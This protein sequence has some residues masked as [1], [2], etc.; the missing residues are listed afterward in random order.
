[1]VNATN[2]MLVLQYEPMSSVICP[3]FNGL[4]GLSLSLFETLVGNIWSYTTYFNVKCRN[5]LG[6][7]LDNCLYSIGYFP[8][9]LGSDGK[10][11]SNEPMF[12]VNLGLA[13]LPGVPLRLVC[14]NWFSPSQ[15][16]SKVQHLTWFAHGW[17]P[18]GLAIGDPFPPTLVKHHTAR[19]RSPA[20]SRRSKKNKWPSGIKALE[21]LLLD[22]FG[23][24]ESNINDLLART[25]KNVYFI[26]LGM[27]VQ[28]SAASSATCWSTKRD[29]WR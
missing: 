23:L 22:T 11:S 15:F 18:F 7:D 5:R 17:Y 2:K 3:G 26:F 1:M 16:R 29:I 21:T 24:Y 19:A 12:L 27:S 10:L 13:S 14:Q 25:K 6:A 8:I 28:A 9:V 4:G 20:I